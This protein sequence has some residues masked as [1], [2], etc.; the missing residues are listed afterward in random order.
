[1][2]TTER[3]KCAKN[4][5]QLA[6][7]SDPDGGGSLHHF[8]GDP[9]CFCGRKLLHSWQSNAQAPILYGPIIVTCG[10][11][12]VLVITPVY[13]RV[14]EVRCGGRRVDVGTDQR[15]DEADGRRRR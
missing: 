9:S 7:F 5:S 4:R 6:P 13:L 15:R 10:G 2:W 3:S 8:L 11:P 12:P 14:V 1:M